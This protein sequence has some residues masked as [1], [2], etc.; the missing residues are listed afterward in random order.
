MMFKILLMA[1]GFALASAQVRL[2]RLDRNNNLLEKD[3]DLKNKPV[4]SLI[5]NNKDK[6]GFFSWFTFLVYESKRADK[7]PLLIK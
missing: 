3:N 2:R 5:Y 1:Q 4:L 6:C 7:I